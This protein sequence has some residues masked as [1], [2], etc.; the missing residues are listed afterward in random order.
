MPVS[1]R[2]RRHGGRGRTRAAAAADRLT[3]G[4]RRYSRWRLISSSTTSSASSRFLVSA[5]M[6]RTRP[7]SAVSTK[8]PSLLAMS[9]Q[10]PRAGENSP[11]ANGVG[12]GASDVAPTS[13]DHFRPRPAPHMRLDSEAF[14]LELS[15]LYAAA[16]DGGAVTVCM[17]RGASPS[18]LCASL[19]R[20]R[21]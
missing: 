3:L 1:I 10:A 16:K 21:P 7:S 14:L 9:G 6:V 20:A 2:K 12:R 15:K 8:Y 5:M 13:L 4:L 19:L 18:R 11:T 17:K